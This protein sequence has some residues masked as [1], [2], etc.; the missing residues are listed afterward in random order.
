LLPSPWLVSGCSSPP[1]SCPRSIINPMLMLLPSSKLKLVL[2]S[3]HE[4]IKRFTTSSFHLL[5][6]NS[7]PQQH[8]ASLFWLRERTKPACPTI[9]FG[10][11]V[12][13]FDSHNHNDTKPSDRLSNTN[14]NRTK[15]GQTSRQTGGRERQGGKHSSHHSSQ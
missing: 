2:S 8:H 7:I 14:W 11:F 13:C 6:V 9:P 4:L 15:R 12:N 10:S 1:C 3:S 5:P